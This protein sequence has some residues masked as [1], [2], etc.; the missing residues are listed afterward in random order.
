[1]LKLRHPLSLLI[2][3]ILIMFGVLQSFSTPEPR[4]ADAP[5]VIFSA[6]RAEALLRDLLREGVPHVSGSPYNLVVRNRLIAQ[7]ESYGYETEIQS[8]FHCNAWYGTCSPV[9]NV[10]AIKPGTKAKNALM[11][12][13]HYDSGWTGPG[14]A[15]DGAGMAAILEI[16]RMAA[17]FPPFE[18]DIVFLFSDSEENGLIGADAFAKHH[19]LID[20]VKAVINLEARG[21]TGS[22]AMFETGDGNRRMIR[23]LSQHVDRPV[24]NSLTYEIYKRMPND[25]D[26]TVYKRKGIPGVNFAFSQ[27]V[28]GYHS[29]IDDPDHLD[30]GSLQHHGDNAWGMLNALADRNLDRISSK[31]DAG[32]IDVFG[33]RLTHYPES[34]ALGLALVLGVWVL[35]AIGLAFRKDFRVWQLRWGLLVV[36]WLFAAIV[37]GGLLLSFPLGHWADLHP[38]EHPYPWMGRLTLFLLLALVLYITLKLFQSRVSPC[39]MMMLSWGLIFVM[40]M[41]L[42]SKLPTAS[43][44][45]VI[46]LAWFVL[47]SLVDMF[48]K[49]S[50]AP[51]LVST[52]LGFAACVFI[53]LYHFF[54][55]EVVLNFDKSHLKVIPLVLMCLAIL[56]MLLAFVKDRELTWQ[57]ARWLLV[58]I[59]AASFIHLSL[60]GFTAERPRGMSLIYNEEEGSDKGYVMLESFM[61]MMDHGFARSH[62]FQMLKLN[63]GWPEPG[64]RPAREVPALNLPGVAIIEQDSQKEEDFWRHRMV[65]QLPERTPFLQLVIAHE[66]GLQKAWVDGQL[67]LDTK[68]ESKQ[69]PPADF[70]RLVYPGMSRVEIEFLTAG[71]G[72]FEVSAITWHDLPG[73]LTAP[74]MGNWPDEARPLFYGPRAQKIQTLEIGQAGL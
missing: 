5:D 2:I 55:L 18:N 31:E 47:G 49:K 67:A 28:A 20:K 25:T 29:V 10:I 11:L 70:I 33:I 42:A 41:V 69:N 63:T 52:V 53:S 61:G 16:A 40:A 12:T 23:L 8:R 74:F 62:N 43:H 14:A 9:D 3:C 54:M 24:A 36:P 32:Y 68:L 48:R 27:G 39:A 44:I 19:P 71:S 56:P 1:M 30:M 37:L 59:L 46:P 50:R 26:Y 13:A 21:I 51:L 6:L 64:E 38:I 73:V 17:D 15:D 58:A 66:D 35:L 57:P 7:L 72:P 34:I 65:L 4:G 22:S 45:A 60:P